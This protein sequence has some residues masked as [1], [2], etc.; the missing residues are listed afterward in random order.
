MKHYDIY[1]AAPLFTAAERE[2]NNR[3]ATVLVGEG[4]SVFLPQSKC[5]G[6]DISVI[7][8]ACLDGI[9]KCRIVLAV[10]DGADADSGTCLEVGYAWARGLP[11]FG[12]RTD[13]RGTGE[14]NG[15]NLMLDKCCGQVF[16][17]HDIDSESFI[18]E[19]RL[20]LP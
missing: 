8:Q 20:N 2:W 15:L 13:S 18:D 5:V 3:I 1:F 16:T 11:I 12:I 6:L 7:A 4:I 9:K 14:K 10:L 17:L 19:L